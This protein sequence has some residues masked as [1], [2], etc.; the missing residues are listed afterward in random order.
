MNKKIRASMTMEAALIIPLF[1]IVVMAFITLMHIVYIQMCVQSA[2][3][4][5]ASAIQSKGIIYEYIYDGVKG[6]ADETKNDI[7]TLIV[8][9]V[10]E[11]D[12]EFFKEALDWSAQQLM[13]IGEDKAFD[14]I[15]K[16]AVTSHLNYIDAD[17]SCIV[18]GQSGIEYKKSHVLNDDGDFVV[19][20]EYKVKVPILFSRSI[21]FNVA[22]CVKARTFGGSLPALTIHD[23]EDEPEEKKEI[24][25]VY[26]TEQGEVYHNNRDCVYLTN[27]M[28]RA[29]KGEMDDK[30][31]NSGSRYYL[32]ERC[33]KLV[34][35]QQDCYVYYSVDGKR[36]HSTLDCPSI[37]RN[38]VEIDIDKI[39]SR[40]ECEKCGD[41]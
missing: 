13:E 32:C 18:G 2:V 14:V 38:V 34:S 41:S 6:K 3:G 35:L 8:S 5:A 7:E 29:L 30:R 15:V 39:E 19:I 22:Q 17:Y 16:K 27:R 12:N 20:A 1:M 21:K 23:E 9:N 31:N 24:N 4:Y 37:A 40:R 10:E 25:K 28:L 33:C 36:Y 26:I 11:L